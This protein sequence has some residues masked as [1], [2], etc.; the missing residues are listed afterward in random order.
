[1]TSLGRVWRKRSRS[2]RRGT[3]T[4]RL[5]AVPRAF[6]MLVASEDGVAGKLMS[7]G[8][9]DRRPCVASSFNAERTVLSPTFVSCASSSTEY[10]AGRRPVHRFAR[11]SC[12]ASQTRSAAKVIFP[13]LRALHTPANCPTVMSTYPP[14]MCDATSPPWGTRRAVLPE[15]RTKDP[16]Q[17]KTFDLD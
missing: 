8:D 2:T 3:G 5:G 10:N 14:R 12:V 13:L 17:P 11:C 15:R 6:A 7:F 9:H 1:M 4:G 16:R